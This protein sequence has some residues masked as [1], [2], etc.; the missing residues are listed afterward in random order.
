MGTARVP[1]PM[2]VV[3]ITPDIGVEIQLT[4]CQCFCCCISAA[5]NTTVKP[6]TRIAEC[7]L[8][9]ATDAAADQGIHLQ[10]AQNSCQRTMAAAARI[11]NLRRNDISIFHIIDFTA[12]FVYILP[13]HDANSVTLSPIQPQE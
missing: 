10:G 5:G 9:T 1:F 4:C 13:N 3:M 2:V 8:R 11:H 7:H 6:D 12:S